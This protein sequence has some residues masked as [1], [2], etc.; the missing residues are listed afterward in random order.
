MNHG[1]GF[2][3]AAYTATRNL[4]ITEIA[5]RIRVNLRNAQEMGALPAEMTFAVR[6]DRYSMGQSIDVTLS[7]MPDAWTF[8]SPGSEAN[9]SE[10]I[11][12]NGGYSQAAQE[13]TSYVNDVVDSYN[14][15]DS[16]SMTDHFDVRFYGRVKIQDERSQWFDAQ[17]RFVKAAQK[18]A[19]AARKAAGLPTKGRDAQWAAAR[20]ARQAR[21]DFEAGAR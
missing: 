1:R 5:K 18:S 17:E 6:I 21:I 3:G 16:D 7:G 13:A 12:P 10:N 8:V 4:D 2:E 11:P 19:A 15:D 14:R 9:W 20:V